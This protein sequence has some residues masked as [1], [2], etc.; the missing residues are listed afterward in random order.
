M[1]DGLDGLQEG[2]RKFFGEVKYYVDFEFS[3]ELGDKLITI[4]KCPIHR[5]MPYNC[6][7]GCT[8]CSNLC[9]ASAID[10]PNIELVR[11]VIKK[12]VVFKVVKEKLKEMVGDFVERAKKY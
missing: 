12:H 10:F 2:Y 3:S 11:E 7:I 6:L 8:T 1:R 5:Y 4:S 9:P